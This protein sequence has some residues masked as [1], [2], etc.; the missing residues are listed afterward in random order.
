MCP[1]SQMQIFNT[2]VNVLLY[3]YSCIN[4]ADFVVLFGLQ[5][6][7]NANIKGFALCG[8]WMFW[9]LLCAFVFLFR[10]VSKLVFTATSRLILYD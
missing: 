8:T 9:L 4:F 2:D 7:G 1:V 3:Q 5:N 10:F 6:E